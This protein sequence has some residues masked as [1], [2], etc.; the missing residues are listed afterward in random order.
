MGNIKN[1]I[2]RAINGYTNSEV[3]TTQVIKS[4]CLSD[5]TLDTI[6]GLLINPVKSK[7][8]PK[9]ESKSIETVTYIFYTLC[10]MLGY[11]KICNEILGITDDKKIEEIK[12]SYKT[13]PQTGFYENIVW[14][15]DGT[16]ASK[17]DPN[18]PLRKIISHKGAF[19]YI[20]FMMGHVNYTLTLSCSVFFVGPRG[21]EVYNDYMKEKEAVHQW[22]DIDSCSETT[23][24]I[25][26]YSMSNGGRWKMQSTT[27]P[28]T[29]IMDHVE[30]D[31]DG[32]IKMIEKSNIIAEDLGINK[33]IGVLLHGPHGSGKSTIARYL[34]LML[35]RSLILTTSDDLPMAIELVQ[36]R[37]SEK[38]IMLIEDIDFMFTDRRKQVAQAPSAASKP[39][40]SKD[41]DDDDDDFRN[42]NDDMNKR[43]SLLFQVL[44]GVLSSSNLIVIAT[45]NYF[46]RLDPALI[47]DGRFDY[48]IELKGLDYNTA[49]KVCERFGVDPADINLNEWKT[50]IAPAT[51]QT[52]LLKYKITNVNTYDPSKV[53]DAGDEN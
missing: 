24:K 4:L 34:A 8:V 1:G 18:Q 32:I 20:E 21:V 45:T 28:N 39:K 49:V 53:D 14:G 26:V 3:L 23:R 31:L 42:S 7:L 36:S 52:V 44:D 50:P 46:N 15:I 11:K 5:Y 29:I 35:G 30:G 40:A 33:T 10:N 51:L 47:R 17:K 38:F 25:K 13:D 6:R 43:T 2:I 27:V 37:S 22:I 19:L 48:K 12:N 9:D 41:E 16:I